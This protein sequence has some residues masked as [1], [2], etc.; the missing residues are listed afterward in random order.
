MS[1]TFSN[2]LVELL[3]KKDTVKVIATTDAL[4]TPHVVV[5]DSLQLNESNQLIYFELLE[6]SQ[7][8]KNLVHSI[9]FNRPVAVALI[10]SG[11]E[12]YQIKGKPVKAIVS[13]LLFRDYYIKIR[14]Q[15][16][17]VDLAAVWVIE[18]FEVIDQRFDTRSQEEAIR[19][20]YFKHLDRLAK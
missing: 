17:D 11:G 15:L 13:G 12:S 9:W 6:S 20:P 10:G 16:G 19:H 3:T 2:E 1:I 14:E 5:K 4:G 18:P 7:T 8:N